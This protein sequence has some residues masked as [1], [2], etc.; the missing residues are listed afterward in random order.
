MCMIHNIN[1][2]KNGTTEPW[3]IIKWQALSYLSC[4]ILPTTQKANFIQ[5]HFK[6]EK[7]G[8]KKS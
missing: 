2:S 1:P 6:A 8:A 4:L 3:A 5:L 7:M